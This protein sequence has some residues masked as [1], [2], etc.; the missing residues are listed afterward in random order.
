MMIL[1]WI[2]IWAVVIFLCLHT[3]IRKDKIEVISIIDENL[4]FGHREESVVLILKD[5][6]RI[7]T[8]LGVIEKRVKEFHGKKI[9]ETTT[10][11]Y[12]LGA[13]YCLIGVVATIYFS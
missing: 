10:F 11:N 1:Y 7:E 5:G 4:G 12:L 6:T 3:A 9:W 8:T 2:F 13:F